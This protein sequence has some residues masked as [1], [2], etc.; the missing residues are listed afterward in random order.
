[1][2]KPCN[3]LY[4]KLSKLLSGWILISQPNKVVAILPIL[5]VVTAVLFSL[6]YSLAQEDLQLSLQPPTTTTA[7]GL[8]IDNS[9]VPN[10]TDTAVTTD[11]TPFSTSDTA[12]PIQDR[13]IIGSFGDDRITGSNETDIIIALLGADTVRGG[14]GDDKIQG[15]EDLDKL[16][17]EDGDDLLQGGT[18]TD[19]LYGGQGDDILSGGMGDNFLVGEQGNDKL[20]GGSEDDILHGGQGAD[21]FD[22]GEGIDI[23][24]DFNIEEGD[25]NAGNCEEISNR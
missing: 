7:P 20:Y 2:E 8:S 25:D 13:V 16:Y 22:C 3:N 18:A 6:D 15:N 9:L 4:Y 14:G 12:G 19:Q 17:G 23:I 11:S 1:L 5:L 21:Y 10:N 24:I